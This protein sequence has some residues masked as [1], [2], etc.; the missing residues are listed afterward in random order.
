MLFHSLSGSPELSEGVGQLMFEV[1]RGVS[2]QFHSCCEGVW[3]LLL[4]KLGSDTAEHLFQAL[5]KMAELMAEHTRK[6]FSAPVWRPLLVRE[7][8]GEEGDKP[9]LLLGEHRQIDQAVGGD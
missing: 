9:F 1:V 7:G 5:A 3:S 8:G 2:K 4:C 6:E